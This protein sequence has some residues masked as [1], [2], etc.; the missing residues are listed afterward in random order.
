MIHTITKVIRASPL[1]AATILSATSANAQNPLSQSTQVEIGFGLA[2][3]ILQDGVELM[4]SKEL[5]EQGLSYYGDQDGDHRNV[6]SYSA[7]R[8]MTLNV[9][10]YKPLKQVR[11]LM[12]GAMV[13]NAQT[14]STPGD[15]YSEGYYFNFITAAVAFKYYPFEKLKVFAKGDFGLAS[16]LTK[17]RF[18]NDDGEQNFFHQFGIGSGG[19]V[20]LGY[21]FTPFKNKSNSIDAQVLYQ[22]LRTRV[23]V[24]DVGDDQ[25]R[26][27]SLNFTLA[28][29]F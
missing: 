16:V 15:G 9:G 29:S 21:S 22:Q 4:R 20:A 13:R 18:I 24:N 17:N 5:R 10:F 23:E 26:F 6:G 12:M 11:G 2:S 7:L 27:G 14:G 8:G 1:A 3:P 19:S 28:M 25:W